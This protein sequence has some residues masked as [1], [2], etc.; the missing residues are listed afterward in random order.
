MTVQFPLSYHIAFPFCPPRA[1]LSHQ[2]REYKRPSGSITAAAQ[3]GPARGPRPASS[4]PQIILCT[5]CRIVISYCKRSISLILN[6]LIRLGVQ[7]FKGNSAQVF[8]H[9]IRP[10]VWQAILSRSIS[11]PEIRNP[12]LS[13]GASPEASYPFAIHVTAQIYT[14]PLFSRGNKPAACSIRFAAR[15]TLSSISSLT[16]PVKARFSPTL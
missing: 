4:T 12:R 15:V 11:P 2:G 9:G 16:A 1:F 5:R 13:A 6:L 10:A 8:R 3:T 14:A 7:L